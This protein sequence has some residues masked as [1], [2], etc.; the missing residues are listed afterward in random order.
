MIQPATFEAE[1]RSQKQHLDNDL[2]H[3]IKDQHDKY[4]HPKL[5]KTALGAEGW[6]GWTY[7]K[8][9]LDAAA[10]LHDLL[11]TFIKQGVIVEED[12]LLMCT[13]PK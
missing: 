9:G 11:T 2:A 7:H 12:G 4:S 8:N 10:Q 6:V 5:A 3:R 13:V 1:A